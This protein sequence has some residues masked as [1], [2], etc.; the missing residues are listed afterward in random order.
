MHHILWRI[1]EKIK[2]GK[3]YSIGSG[4]IIPD[5]LGKLAGTRKQFEYMNEPYNKEAGGAEF[6]EYAAAKEHFGEMIDTVESD[7]MHGREHGDVEKFVMTQGMEALRRVVQGHLNS[8]AK[9]EPLRDSVTGTDGI[10]RNHRRRDCKHDLTTVFGEVEV[11]RI[12]YGQPGQNSLYPLDAQL[13]LPENKY[14][15]GMQQRSA[16]EVM[17]VSFDVAINNVAGTTGG[18]IPKHQ[19]QDLAAEIAQDFDKFYST[20]EATVP[21]ETTDPL[22]LTTDGKG[23][24]M[25]KNA[26]R[27]QT[28]KAADKEKRKLKTRLSPGEKGNRKRMATV[29]SVYSVARHNRTAEMIMGISKDEVGSRIKPPKVRNKRVW[30]SV[31][32]PA[33]DVVNDIFQEALRRDPQKQRPWAMLIDGQPQQLKNVLS[34]IKS[35]KAEHIVIIMDLIHVIEYLWK[36][37]HA[38]FPEGSAAAEKWVKEHELAILNGKASHVAAGMRRSATRRGLSKKK[39]EAVDICARY[40]LTN[41]H[42]M[43]YHEFLKQGLPI[44][45]GVIEGACRHLINDRMDITGARWGLKTAE[46]ILR[47]RSL[48][49]SEDFAEYW[50][51]HKAKELQ[52]THV[53]K[54]HSRIWQEAA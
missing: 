26:L 53:V 21:E 44:A 17:N 39:R 31:E 23:I 3:L 34:C 12:G 7:E 41:S 19:M 45:T 25:V 24:V 46:G 18:K 2:M 38:F 22:I 16:E 6:D 52:R 1:W 28:R 49:S 48:R 40:L 10:E 37:A 54:F 43:R 11:R 15:H 8:R 30:A 29:A 4:G 27:E 33:T 5:G 32:R 13:N 35:Y 51:F 36:A 14:S 42:Y 47:L 20:R 9:R 50:E